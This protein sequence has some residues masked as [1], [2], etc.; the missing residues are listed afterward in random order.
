MAKF[1][2]FIGLL[3]AGMT[4]GFAQGEILS[5]KKKKYEALDG[6]E[7]QGEAGFMTVPEN[8]S[9]PDSRSI[10]IKFIR[11][12]S[13]SETPKD[14]VIYLEGGGSA[15]TW[16]AESP[17]DLNYWLP[18]L[19]VA[20]LI[21][22]DQR[23]TADRKLIH[24]QKGD[25]PEDFFVSEDA[26]TNYYQTFAK[27]AL[28]VF[29]KK[30]IDVLGYTIAEHAT[31]IHELAEALKIDRYSIFGFS[32]GT[33]IGMSLMKMYPK[34]ITNAVLV[35]ADGPGQS[36]NLPS[37]L[38]SCFER[39]NGLSND[40]EVINDKI[41]DLDNL[42]DR[43]ME[44]LKQNPALVTVKHPL[45]KKDLDVKVGP[46]GLSLILRLDIDDRNDIPVI[47]R[48]LYTI[49]QGDYSIL[50]WFLQKRVRFALGLPGN[51][52]NQ[53]IASG[54]S[55]ER[56]KQIQNE[57]AESRFGNVVN[58]PFGAAVDVWPNTS[59]P[60]DSSKPLNSSIRTLFVTGDLDCRTPVDQISQLQQEFTNA[61][62]IVVKNA[63]HE[64]ALWNVPV[65]DRIIPGFLKGEELNETQVTLKEKPF[66]PVTGPSEG[67]PSIE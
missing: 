7:I 54:A 18:I 32:F 65:F 67:H 31:D 57:A 3:V 45:S 6:L 46:F 56:M 25:F 43:V 15:C 2:T 9:N 66:I 5:I 29:S 48:L 23:G 36:F 33:S 42:L 50:R 12:K 35:S 60:F 13:L 16:Q 59:L 24:I 62:H 63:G 39:I 30:G 37:Y 34:K 27:E 19:N 1:L 28:A 11:L 58:F 14:P 8:R 61:T 41:P 26:A 64:G 52:I 20:D 44:K 47:P 51:G 40:S 49:D 22:V 38:D 55:A 10:K 21:F 17:Q 53:G 4:S